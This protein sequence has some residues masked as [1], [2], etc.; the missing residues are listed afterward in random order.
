MNWKLPLIDAHCHSTLS[1]EAAFDP[2]GVM[3][4]MRQ[5]KRNYIQQLIHGVTTIR[6]MGALPKM[7]HDNLEMI[8][9]DELIGPRVVYCNAFTNIRGG[10]PDVDPSDISIFS[11]ITMAFTGNPNLWFADTTELQGKIKQ[12]AANGAS[13]IKLTMD[14]KSLMCGKGDIP[15]YSDEHLQAIL[16]F[17]QKNNMPTAGHIHTKFGFDRALQYGINSM[18]H[19]ITDAIL[20]DGEVEEMAKKHIAIVPT[21]I[22]AQM[23]SCEEAYTELPQ[24]FQT[25]FIKNE[26]AI[27]RK[28]IQLPLDDYID[29]Q[30]HK[31]NIA[32]LQNYKKYGCEDLY[33]KGKFLT[34]ADI[35][36]NILLCGPKNLLKMKNAGI[37]IGCGTDAGI[38]LMYHGA[39]WREMEMLCRI[40]FSNREVLECA[41]INNARILRM[42]DKI[43]SIEKGKFADIVV[44]KENPLDKIETCREPQIVIKNGRIYDVAQI[45]F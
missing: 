15:A 45:T 36:F 43:G 25:E 31:N 12:N 26:L 44:L 22:I 17:A 33:K 41:T 27:R 2:F 24:E 1:C 28:Y 34:R 6:D 3:T 8:E 11:G 32:A 10:H 5:I 7:L 16:E 40:G 29:P 9:K 20:T 19:S 23:L 13:F 42:A 38:A 39:L 21:M 18:E 30:I 35:Y 4:T 14:K 37:M